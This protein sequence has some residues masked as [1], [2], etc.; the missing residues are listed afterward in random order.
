MEDD[1]VRLKFSLSVV[2]RTAGA[3]KSP[4][5]ALTAEELRE[6]AEQAIAEEAIKRMGK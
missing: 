3:L 5:P 2:E 1:Q 4:E 6:V